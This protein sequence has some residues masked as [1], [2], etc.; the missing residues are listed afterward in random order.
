[1]T[2]KQFTAFAAVAKHR[3]ITKAAQALGVSQPSISK[4]LKT[5]EEKYNVKLLSRDAGRIELTE[6]GTVL[7]R[8]VEGILSQL[9]RIEQRFARFARNSIS[10]RPT[11]LK[12]AGSYAAS[13]LLLPSL[14]AL[15]KRKH[16]DVPIVLR[17]G[18]TKNIKE[19]L[20]KSEV[21]IALLNETPVNPNLVGEVFRKE[22]LV[23]FAAANH[24]LARKKQLRLSDLN[25]AP[26]V[27]TG[28]K[29]RRSTTEKILNGLADQGFRAK[30]AIRC[31][32]PESVKA[33]VKKQIGVGILF[34]DTVMPEIKKKLFKRLNCGGLKLVGQSYIVYYNNR[35][36]TPG[37]REFLTLLR[38][39]GDKNVS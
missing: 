5:L 19:M 16:S 9:Q 8:D 7:L 15:F 22:Q 32:T 25:A 11:V 38:T 39:R 23:V 33:I 14:L 30:I 13:A 34:R 21:E 36:L 12:I 3:S 2:F 28:G 1:V 26:L 18:S 31:G 24:P 4:H 10:E 29:G 20:L 17:T 35:L 37:A 27:A 6:E